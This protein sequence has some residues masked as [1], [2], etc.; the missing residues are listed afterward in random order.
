MECHTSLGGDFKYETCGA[1][2][3]ESKA[4]NHCKFCKC[5]TCS[6]CVAPTPASTGKARSTKPAIAPA[7][8]AATVAATATATAPATKPA[9]RRKGNGRKAQLSQPQDRTVASTGPTGPAPQTAAAPALAVPSATAAAAA[10]PTGTSSWDPVSS[11]LLL[12][13]V[14]CAAALIWIRV[15]QDSRREEEGHILLDDYHSG[16]PSQGR[17]GLSDEASQD[18][19]TPEASREKY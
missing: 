12:V 10:P 17:R 5:R 19:D 16:A 9:T 6:F 8:V 2:C 7:T 15:C 18:V 3:K 13:G 4:K 11:A 14:C 1:F